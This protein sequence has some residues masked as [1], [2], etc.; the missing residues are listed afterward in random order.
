MCRSFIE[1]C[2]PFCS[3]TEVTS[4]FGLVQELY[5]FFSSSISRWNLLTSVLPKGCLVP[6]SLS[7]TRWS[8]N[9][10][11]VKAPTLSYIPILETLDKMKNDDSQKSGT[12][13]DAKMLRTIFC[14]L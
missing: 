1:S 11:A 8:A 12:R 10:E 14:K 7:G 5:N 2:W 3:Y 6:K 9:A 13:N 4:F